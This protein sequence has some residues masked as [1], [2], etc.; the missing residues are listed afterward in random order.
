[1]IMMAMGHAVAVT[2][3]HKKAKASLHSQLF[4]RTSLVAPPAGHLTLPDLPVDVCRTLS[5]P[6]REAERVL[7]REAFPWLLRSHKGMPCAASRAA[8]VAASLH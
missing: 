2:E 4:A 7:Q 8:G 5:F 1:M 3:L 6:Q